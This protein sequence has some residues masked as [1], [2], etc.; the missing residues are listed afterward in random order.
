MINVLSYYKWKSRN[1]FKEKRQQMLTFKLLSIDEYSFYSLV[2]STKEIL[3]SCLA[4]R[5]W[6]RAR[7][8]SR[9]V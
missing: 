1:F 5:A 3:L 8:V 4:S 9:E 2:M 7:A 6:M